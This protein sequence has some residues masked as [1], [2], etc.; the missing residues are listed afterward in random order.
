VL[1]SLTS[2]ERGPWKTKYASGEYAEQL[3]TD[4]R[5][6]PEADIQP[7]EQP[8]RARLWRETG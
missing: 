8:I 6:Q 1:F 3:P 5:S 2:T 4:V 7:F